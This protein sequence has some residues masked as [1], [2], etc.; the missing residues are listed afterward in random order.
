MW[1]FH[2]APDGSRT[3]MADSICPTVFTFLSNWNILQP[4]PNDARPYSVVLF[5]L[6][7]AGMIEAIAKTMGMPIRLATFQPPLLAQIGHPR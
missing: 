2:G 4:R 7:I 6:A 5:S 3:S 1:N